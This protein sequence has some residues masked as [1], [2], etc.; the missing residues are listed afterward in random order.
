MS[1]EKHTSEEDR[2]TEWEVKGYRGNYLCPVGMERDTEGA[3]AYRDT[4]NT[5]VNA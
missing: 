5:H 4:D 1:A 2:R 3:G